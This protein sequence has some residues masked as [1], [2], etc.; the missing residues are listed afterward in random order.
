MFQCIQKLKK[1]LSDV[2]GHKL[3]NRKQILIIQTLHKLRRTE[4]NFTAKHLMKE[5]NI[6]ESEV[7]VCTVSRFINS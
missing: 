1:A 3:S 7:S 2:V 5:V 4:G 6:L